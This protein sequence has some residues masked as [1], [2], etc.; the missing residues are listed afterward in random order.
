MLL[1]SC[2]HDDGR[3]SYIRTNAAS[4]YVFYEERFV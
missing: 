3:K 1:F 4:L 2:R